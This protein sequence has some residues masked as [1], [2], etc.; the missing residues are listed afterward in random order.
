MDGLKAFFGTKSIWAWEHWKPASHR[1]GAYSLHDAWTDTNI[2]TD[3][4]I[5]HALDVVFSG[6]AQKSAWYIAIFNDDY[7]PL[8]GDGYQ[9]P[10]YTESSNYDEGAR[11]TWQEAGVVSKS[12]TNASNRASLTMSATET[13]YGGSL[14]SAN[15]KGDAVSGEILYCTSKFTVPKPVDDDDVLKV[16]VVIAGQDV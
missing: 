3:E 14:V 6:G 5:T 12:L 10:G 7:T 4:G 16:T 11:P 1:S 8:A 13:I 15:T 9:S 2:T